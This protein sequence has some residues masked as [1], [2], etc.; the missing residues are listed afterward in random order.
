MTDF[1]YDLSSKAMLATLNISVW[2][3]KKYDRK[4]SKEIA[5]K[6][7][8]KETVGRYNKR[9]GPEEYPLLAEI[10]SLASELREYFNHHTLAWE[11]EATRVLPSSKYFE[12][13]QH[14]EELMEKFFQKAD[15]FSEPLN[16]ERYL[17]L[18]REALPGDLFKEEDY[19]KQC[20]IRK[21][22]GVRFKIA[23]LP[24]STDFRVQWS[25]EIAE[26]AKAELEGKLREE[27]E[28]DAKAIYAESMADIYRRVHKCVTD[29][30]EKLNAMELDEATGKVLHPFRNTVTQPLTELVEVLPSLNVMEDPGL[31]AMGEMLKETLLAHTP[32]QLRDNYVSRKNT[33]AAADEIAKQMSAFLGFLRPEAA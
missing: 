12:V 24:A 19:P 6:R 31:A 22:F 11:S 18:A 25:R 28:A 15:E 30:A 17:D 21:K 1:S 8:A 29:M 20:E 3:A 26:S 33:A 13:N 4:I 23:P 2:S 16:W 27:Y 14:L 5:D 10:R 7:G 32:E 9:L